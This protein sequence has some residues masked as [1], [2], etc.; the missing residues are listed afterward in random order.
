MHVFFNHTHGSLVLD[1]SNALLSKGLSA[2]YYYYFYYLT[3][4]GR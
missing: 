2:L 1:K 4:G 3:N